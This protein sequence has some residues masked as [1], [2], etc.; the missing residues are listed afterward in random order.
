M[1]NSRIR[2]KSNAEEDHV[3][4]S[5]RP[6][7]FSLGAV[8]KMYACKAGPLKVIE[9]VDPSAYVL[10]SPLNLDTSLTFNILNLVMFRAL[11]MISSKIFGPYPILER[12]TLPECPLNYPGR[13]LRIERDLDG[14]VVM[15]QDQGYL[16]HLARWLYRPDFEGSWIPRKDPQHHDPTLLPAPD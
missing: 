15:T 9:T 1:V 12:E 14:Q 13:E 11:A 10:K 5:S 8:K 7:R 2:V 3:E 16:Y 6:E 4:I